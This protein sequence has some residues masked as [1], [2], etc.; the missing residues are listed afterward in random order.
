MEERMMIEEGAAA[1]VAKPAAPHRWL[2]ACLA[3]LLSLFVVRPWN[4][5]AFPVWDYGDMLPLLRGSRGL[6]GAFS[7]LSD[8]SRADG[9]ANYLE[10]L[11]L[12]L[13]WGIAGDNPVAWQWE[14]ALV[15]LAAALLFVV[16]A[17]RLGATPLAAGI[18]ATLLMVAV[19]STEGWLF[20]MG[21]PL[22]VI[23]LLLLVL[24][25]AGYSTTPAWRSRAMLI[26]VL[27]ALVMLTKEVLGV[28][29]PVLALFAITW[30]PGGGFKRPTLGPRERWLVL[31][32]LVVLLLEGWSV[33]G[34]F[35][36]AAP[37]SYATAFGR[38]GLDGG[39]LLTLFQAM[40]LPARFSSASVSTILYPANLAFLLLLILGLA[41]RED[42]AA[43][44]RGWGWWV[45]GL[46]SFPLAG[47]LTYA[48]WPR[49]S[50]FYG[51][52]F[53]AG[54]A[55]LLAVAAT[56]V[57]RAHRAGRW[58]AGL[59]GATA[60]VFSAVVSARTVQEKRA[61]AGLA[62]GISRSFP[63]L[64]RLDTL[65]VVVPGQGG[66]RWPVTGGELRRYA[67]AIGVPDSTLPTMVDTPCEAVVHRLEQPLG[68]S[69]VLNDLNPCGRLPARSRTWLAGVRYLDLLS[70]RR[71]TDTL[72]VD[73]LAPSWQ[74][75]GAVR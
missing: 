33:L 14:R 6:W 5:G 27:A 64:P 35:R 43:K 22:A 15:M 20:I 23:L 8:W 74:G 16:V 50:A 62:A 11:Q 72:L 17:R 70:M 19:P 32:L 60:I 54:S 61:I 58:I 24:A 1:P 65:F 52:P 4:P 55:G 66:R 29:L 51:I 69:G 41:R 42:H 46:I 18:A 63:E 75:T 71:R 30:I 47:A 25:S 28:C 9:R 13:T 68:N 36:D 12:A 26:G 73:L 44:G 21:E 40:L 59:L 3:P 56:S 53:F 31:V 7:A 49:Y 57:E 67:V 10:Y 48:F 34:A 38:G 39:R 45:A 2:L 37:R